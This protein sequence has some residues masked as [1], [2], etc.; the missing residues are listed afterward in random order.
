MFQ[1][2]R[3]LGQGTAEGIPPEDTGRGVYTPEVGEA[4]RR[5]EAA[6]DTLASGCQ[7]PGL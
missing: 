5:R 2:Q 3:R 4:R 7:P 6:F 1:K